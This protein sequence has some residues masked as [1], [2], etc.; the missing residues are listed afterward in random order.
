MQGVDVTTLTASKEGGVTLRKT[1]LKQD[2]YGASGRVYFDQVGGD[3][4]GLPV[5]VREGY[6]KKRQRQ[7]QEKECADITCWERM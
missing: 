2:F 1:L 7:R 5:K 6:G 3:R 4:R